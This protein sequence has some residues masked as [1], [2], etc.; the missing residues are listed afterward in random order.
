MLIWL[1][2][3]TR[4]DF[5]HAMNRATTPRGLKRF[6]LKTGI[7]IYRFLRQEYIANPAFLIYANI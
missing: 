2:A 4:D 7:F 3:K 5:L 1:L 6:I